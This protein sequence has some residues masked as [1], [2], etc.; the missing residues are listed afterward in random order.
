MRHD[1]NSAVSGTYGY[2]DNSVGGGLTHS[3]KLGGRFSCIVQ[4]DSDR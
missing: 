1:R 4:I 2:F 3:L